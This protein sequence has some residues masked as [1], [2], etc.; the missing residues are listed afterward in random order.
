MEF[1][2][3]IIVRDFVEL[4]V[5][6][7]LGD[8]HDGR[9]GVGAVGVPG[10]HRV[11]RPELESLEFELLECL[12]IVMRC[13]RESEPLEFELLEYLEVIVRCDLK[14]E[15][16]EYCV[17]IPRLDVMHQPAENAR[18]ASIP[19]RWHRDLGPELVPPEDGSG[20][21]ARRPWQ[22]LSLTSGHSLPFSG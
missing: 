2:D 17:I 8:H 7:V 5:R 10:D 1:E 19:E 4:G 16:L 3:C 13:D 11:V 12:E 18:S 22:S 14:F 20:R 15:L 6:G 21:G 9:P